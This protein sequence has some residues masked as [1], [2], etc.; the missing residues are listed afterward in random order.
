MWCKNCKTEYREGI[1]VCA[2]CGA[3]LVDHLDEEK[4]DEDNAFSFTEDDSYVNNNADAKSLL[5]TSSKS[6]VKKADQYKD[7]K[8]SGISFL[9]FGILGAVYLILCKTEIIPISYNLFIFIGISMMFVIFIIIGIVSIV[10]AGGIKKQIPEEEAQTE[11]IMNWLSD[12]MLQD[13][14][15]KWKDETV[16][17]AENDLLVTAKIL[18]KLVKKYP[19][20]DRSYLEMI[21]DEYF[22]SKVD[23]DEDLSDEE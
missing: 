11:E 13:N 18:E 22:E 2:E 14:I 5:S 15:D 17:A 4:N 6:Y 16:S 19:D 3:E 7:M 20:L 1:K 10:K 12:N 21:A 9:I 23:S 8:F